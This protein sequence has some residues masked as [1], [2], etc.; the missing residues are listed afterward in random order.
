MDTIIFVICVDD[1]V[2]FAVTD[3]VVLAGARISLIFYN[4]DTC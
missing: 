4:M 1:A 2:V 3:A